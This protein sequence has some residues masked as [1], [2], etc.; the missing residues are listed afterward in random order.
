MATQPRQIAVYGKGGIGK[1]TIVQNVSAALVEQKLRVL[2]VGCDPKHDSS[3]PFLAGQAPATIVDLL[4]SDRHEDPSPA[5]FLMKTASGV[6]CIEVGGPKPGVGCAGAGILTMFDLLEQG[7]VLKSG[8]DVVLYDVLGD[9]VCGGFAAPMRKGYA[10]ETVVVVSGEFMALYA[11]NNICRGIATYAQRREVRLAGV[12]LN[13]RNVPNEEA[14]AREFS[15]RI[16]GAYLGSVPRDPS[17]SQAEMQRR[18]VLS[19]SPDS[20]QADAY[21][22]LTDTILN[23][24]LLAAPEPMEDRELEEMYFKLAYQ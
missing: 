3:R 18:T 12:V 21:R 22:Q 10:R 2:Q 1:S 9:V 8:Y 11:A 4:A 5:D 16:G 6:D 23:N 14:I 19:A 7:Q 17:V 13:C 15:A 24:R 20:A